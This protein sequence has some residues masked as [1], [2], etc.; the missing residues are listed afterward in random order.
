[1]HIMYMYIYLHIMCI[2]IYIYRYNENILCKCIY[3]THFIRMY[4][5]YISVCDVW[6]NQESSLG[7]SPDS[8]FVGCY[9]W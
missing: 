4:Y 7:L 8:D 1:M 6:L 2:Y 3:Y 9:T 5:E